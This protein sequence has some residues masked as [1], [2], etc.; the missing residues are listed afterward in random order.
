MGGF[1]QKKRAERVICAGICG[2]RIRFLPEK[3]APPLWYLNYFRESRTLPTS[4]S[5]W[6]HASWRL[7]SAFHSTARRMRSILDDIVLPLWCLNG[8]NGIYCRFFLTFFRC[9]GTLYS[10]NFYTVIH[11]H[12]RNFSLKLHTITHFHTPC[13]TQF[14]LRTFIIQY[15]EYSVTIPLRYS[16]RTNSMCVYVICNVIL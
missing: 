8:R 2:N 13:C 9:S 3:V 11:T 1:Y 12:N 10:N 14:Y 16:L 15:I 5:C 7:K 6:R 4:M